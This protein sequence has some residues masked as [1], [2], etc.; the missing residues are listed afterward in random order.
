[1]NSFPL[2]IKK[3]IEEV[4]WTFAKTYAKTWPHEYIIKKKVDEKK[5]YKLA[6]H[7]RVFGYLAPFYSQKYHYFDDHSVDGI[8]TY[9]TLCPPPSDPQWFSLF[10]TQVINRC[11][12]ENTYEERLKRKDLPEN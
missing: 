7:L 4:P 1:M 5:F 10:E 9:W 11:T 2:E 6:E 8:M 3:F 12:K